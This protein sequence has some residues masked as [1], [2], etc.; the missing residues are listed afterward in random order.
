MGSSMK[1]KEEMFPSSSTSTAEVRSGW[2]KTLTS[3]MSP[4]PIRYRRM[5]WLST[6]DGWKSPPP[7]CV[8]AS[9]V[10]PRAAKTAN[11]I[12]SLFLMQNLEKSAEINHRRLRL[13]GVYTRRLDA[14]GD[15]KMPKPVNNQLQ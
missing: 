6:D 14:R 10:T 7:L 15:S 3:R 9:A 8:C 1:G 12:R 2:P 5:P 4:A 11:K 13:I